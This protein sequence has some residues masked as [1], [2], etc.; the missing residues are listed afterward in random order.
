MGA[1]FS[2]SEYLDQ[3]FYQ[4]WLWFAFT[5]A[6]VFILGFN[7]LAASIGIHGVSITTLMQKMSIVLS[8]SLSLILYQ[9]SL[10]WQKLIGIFIGVCAVLLSGGRSV[11]KNKKLNSQ[12]SL[13]VLPL[14]V[15]VVSAF[16]ELGLQYAE[17]HFLMGND[18][19]LFNTSLF[20][21][22][23]ILGV[24]FLLYRHYRMGDSLVFRTRDLLGGVLLGIPNYFSIYFLIMSISTGLEGSFVFP[25][26]NISVLLLSITGSVILFR[27]RLERPQFFGLLLAIV[28]I[29]LISSSLNHG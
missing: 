21:F 20:S 19:H 27:E 3:L 18:R 2:S 7:V 8:A 10:G 29:V 25:V 12:N 22:A 9:E 17:I 14:L 13:Y 11:F 28:S 5:L 23:G 15:L 1:L 4:P 6:F 24:L 16:V 26:I